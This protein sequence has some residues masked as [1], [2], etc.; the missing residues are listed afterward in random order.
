MILKIYQMTIG[1]FGK[2]SGTAYFLLISFLSSYVSIVNM[3]LREYDNAFNTFIFPD[4]DV[5]KVGT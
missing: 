1:L 5:L 4:G 3:E 2:K